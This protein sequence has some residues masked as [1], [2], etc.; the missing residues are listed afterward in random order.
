M[1]SKLD[2]SAIPGHVEHKSAP[3]ATATPVLDFSAIPGH[4]QHSDAAVPETTTLEQ[5]TDEPA[6]ATWGSVHPVRE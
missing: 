4:V 5:T 6:T 1:M 3:E 2:F